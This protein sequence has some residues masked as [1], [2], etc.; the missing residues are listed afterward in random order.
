MYHLISRGDGRRQLFQNDGHDQ[1][2]TR[3]LK[4]EVQRSGWQVLAY[5]WMPKTGTAFCVMFARA[6]VVATPP[7]SSPNRLRKSPLTPCPMEPN[8]QQ[9]LRAFEPR[10]FARFV[11]LARFLRAVR[12]RKCGLAGNRLAKDRSLCEAETRVAT[13]AHCGT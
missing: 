8:Y 2:L 1:R 11:A 13:L 6:G 3:G 5:C 12:A 4:E 7:R 10:E 9:D